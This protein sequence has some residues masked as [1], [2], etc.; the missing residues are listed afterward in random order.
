MKTHFALVV[1]ALITYFVVGSLRAQVSSLPM[2]SE[3][4][5]TEYSV[6][7]GRN[8]IVYVWQGDPNFPSV[9]E[10][11]KIGGLSFSTKA[12][13]DAYFSEKLKMVAERA[14]TNAALDKDFPIEVEAYFDRAYSGGAIFN[15]LGVMSEFMLKVSNGVYSV[16]DLSG[17][18][19]ELPNQ[20]PYYVP[21]LKWVRVEVAN[22]GGETLDVW[23]SNSGSVSKVFNLTYSTLL[24]HK[25]LAL[26]QPGQ[27]LKT[28]IVS[29]NSNQFQ[30]FDRNGS[31]IPEVLAK[32]NIGIYSVSSS[33]DPR[34]TL[35]PASVSSL[36]V[37]VI[38]GEVGRTYKVQ[39]SPTPEGPW[40]EVGKYTYT[41]Y[42]KDH[43]T[44]F[45][46][47]TNSFFRTETVN[48]VPRY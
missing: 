26:G 24:I 16:P 2:G 47:E 30:V 44:F 21:K 9:F 28:R 31:Q 45:Q 32:L 14:L 42:Q 5:V 12:Q 46:T 25:N 19:L 11:F 35:A 18:R 33:R 13:L 29:G 23:D 39:A 27:H 34:V 20:I 38:T 15:H 48:E 3:E 4:R 40:T 37:Q 1:V 17:I 6:T 22:D 7:A 10:D 43:T 36:Y 8:L 41:P